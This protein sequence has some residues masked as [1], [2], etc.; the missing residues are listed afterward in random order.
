[1]EPL[2]KQLVRLPISQHPPTY[3]VSCSGWR[4]RHHGWG[5]APTQ[6]PVGGGGYTFFWLNIFRPVKLLK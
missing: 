3:L 4:R 1:M 2:M 5:S 6:P